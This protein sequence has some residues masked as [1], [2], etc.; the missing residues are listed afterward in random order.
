[1]PHQWT[2]GLD[3]HVTEMGEKP[4]LKGYQGPWILC[5]QGWGTHIYFFLK[6][7][8]NQVPA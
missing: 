7:P 4:E 8:N 2:E 1:M 5:G 6:Q 3:G